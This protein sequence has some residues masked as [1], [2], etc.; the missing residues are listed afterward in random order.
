MSELKFDLEEWKK[1]NDAVKWQKW[2]KA[3]AIGII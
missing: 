3:I 2:K 1:M